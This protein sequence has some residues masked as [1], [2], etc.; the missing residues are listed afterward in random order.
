VSR[1][2]GLVTLVVLIAAAVT[3]T[4]L[5]LPVPAGHHQIRVG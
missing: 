2:L 1:A 4:S 3:G 5:S